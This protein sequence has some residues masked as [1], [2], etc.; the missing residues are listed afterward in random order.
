LDELAPIGVAAGKSKKKKIP[1]D[2]ARIVL[3]AFDFD[4][5]KLS[6]ERLLQPN[7]RQCLA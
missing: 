7:A 1:A 4:T 6:R 5:C 2:P 3:Q